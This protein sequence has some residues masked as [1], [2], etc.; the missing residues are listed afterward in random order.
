MSI[1]FPENNLQLRKVYW[2]QSEALHGIAFLH[3]QGQIN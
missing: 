3:A 2:N 1:Y